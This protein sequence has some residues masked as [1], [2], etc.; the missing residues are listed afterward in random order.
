MQQEPQTLGTRVFTD[1]S[2]RTVYLDLVGRQYVLDD[3]GRP[4]HGTWLA[5]TPTR[6]DGKEDNNLVRLEKL[7]RETGGLQG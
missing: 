1:G 2:T 5:H 6:P 3:D 7:A 4:I